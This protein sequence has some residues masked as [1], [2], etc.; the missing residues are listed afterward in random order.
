MLIA[1]PIG[2]YDQHRGMQWA[3]DECANRAERIRG[4]SN[5]KQFSHV[6]NGHPSNKRFQATLRIRCSAPELWRWR[7]LV[8]VYW[9][10]EEIG[11]GIT[12]TGMASCQ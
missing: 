12:E 6:R 9:I 2:L 3:A 5:W 1:R 11:N 8:S 10:T 7:S 4:V